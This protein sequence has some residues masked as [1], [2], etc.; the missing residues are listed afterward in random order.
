M[1][2][3]IPVHRMSHPDMAKSYIEVYRTNIAEE[4]VA[5]QLAALLRS[6]YPAYKVNFDL[7]DCDHILRIESAGK[8]IDCQGVN[9]L[10]SE[11]GYQVEPLAD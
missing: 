3:N 5:Q 2:Q 4:K 7:E 11:A 9:A 10:C 6:S 8:S 1:Q